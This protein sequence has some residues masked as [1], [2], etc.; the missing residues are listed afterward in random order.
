[1]CFAVLSVPCS[2]EVTCCERADLLAVACA[3]LSCVLS[4]SQMCPGPHQNKGLG[5]RSETGLSPPEN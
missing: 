4:L 2:L 3:M 5:W 1:M